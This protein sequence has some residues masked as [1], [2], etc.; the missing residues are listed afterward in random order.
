MST[1]FG[2]PQNGQP[3]DDKKDIQI[4]KFHVNTDIRAHR[5]SKLYSQIDCAASVGQCKTLS[6]LKIRSYICKEHSH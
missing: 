3:S 6:N 1:S 4:T 2:R 5:T